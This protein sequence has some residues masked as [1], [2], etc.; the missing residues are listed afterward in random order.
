MKK[1]LRILLLSA[2]FAAA[3]CISASATEISKNDGAY[4][5]NLKGGVTLNFYTSTGN[6][7]IDDTTVKFSAEGSDVTGFYAEAAR[8]SFAATGTA[9][10]Q[11]LLLVCKGDAAPCEENIVYIN[12][13]ASDADG[14]ISFTG[15][16]L[17]YPG[18]M[19]A[20]TYYVYVVGDGRGYDSTKTAAENAAASFRT[21][22]AYKLGD[23]N[24]DS[25]V[26]VQDAVA[27]LEYCVGSR[28]LTGNAKLAA[29]ANKD[30][31]VN[32]QDAVAILEYCVGSR[33]L[34]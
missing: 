28:V 11:Y 31:A 19:S 4:D 12:Q 18:D 23:A 27:V 13:T 26:N 22:N 17:A 6:A 32:V 2:V 20:D 16:K 21:Y 1:V 9:N 7:P 5:V 33:T 15:D 30:S 3:L 34:N 25:A 14:N 24:M 10:K 29:N 8:F